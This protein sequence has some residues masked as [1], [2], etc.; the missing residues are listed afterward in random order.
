MVLHDSSGKRRLLLCIRVGG[1]LSSLRA[2]AAALHL[3][4]HNAPDEVDLLIFC[5]SLSLLDI[6]QRW[7]N[8]DFWP[9]AEEI[10][11]F[12]IITQVLCTLRQR[13]G[14]TLLFKVK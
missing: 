14:K 8:S 12:D 11:H 9:R 3:L 4:L 7:G 1:R 10:E 2:E 6:L 5:Y 13:K